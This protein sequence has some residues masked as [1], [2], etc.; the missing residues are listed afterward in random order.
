MRFI[1][2]QNHMVVRSLAHPIYIQIYNLLFYR[3]GIL[4][5]ISSIF[6]HLQIRSNSILSFTYTFMAV[7]QSISMSLY[8]KNS[9]KST[10]FH[11][12]KYLTP[13]HIINNPFF[14]IF[15]LIKNQK[16]N[17]AFAFTY[18]TK[19]VGK[20]QNHANKTF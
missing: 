8:Q 20:K 15:L 2:S 10:F 9:I 17:R 6:K 14:V 18:T 5:H 3:Y 7:Q 13:T 1:S 19:H 16:S 4:P 11:Y 12:L